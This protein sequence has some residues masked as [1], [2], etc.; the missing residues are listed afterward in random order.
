MDPIIVRRH[1]GRWSVQQD[2]ATA[3]EAEYDTR[4]LAEL[5]ARDIAG[6]S[7]REVVVEEEGDGLD[8]TGHPAPA[9]RGGSAGAGQAGASADDEL[10]REPQAGL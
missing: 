8:D 7:G 9:G 4:E 1:G 2:A 5:A 3:P 6:E 10:P